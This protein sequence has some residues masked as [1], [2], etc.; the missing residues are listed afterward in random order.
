M[1]YDITDFKTLM[2]LEEKGPDVFL[3]LSP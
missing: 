1:A 3:G 2:D